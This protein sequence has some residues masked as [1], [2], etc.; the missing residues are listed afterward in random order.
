M[1]PD[2][3]LTIS[4]FGFVILAVALGNWW[5]SENSDVQRKKLSSLCFKKKR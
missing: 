1:D 2:F 5:R 3:P 4:V